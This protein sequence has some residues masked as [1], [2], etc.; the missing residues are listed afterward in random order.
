MCSKCNLYYLGQTQNSIKIRISNHLSDIRKYRQTPVSLHFNKPDH[1]LNDFVFFPFLSN[2]SWKLDKR[3]EKENKYIFKFNTL[4][5]N[6][7]NISK[8]GTKLKYIVIPYRGNKSIP[9]ILLNNR[10]NDYK[11]SFTLGNKFRKIFS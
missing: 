10:T 6:G 5:P 1:S 8:S 4:E 11:I 7:L 9:N 3:L 2:K